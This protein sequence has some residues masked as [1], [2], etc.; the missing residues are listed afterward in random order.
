MED[1]Y[2]ATKSS[3]IYFEVLYLQPIRSSGSTALE[4]SARA[5]QHITEASP[6]ELELG[7]GT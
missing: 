3:N 7:R 1:I 5:E 2:V 4:E 6:N